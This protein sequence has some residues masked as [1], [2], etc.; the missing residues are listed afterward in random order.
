MSHY[1]KYSRLR[2]VR[3]WATWAN[4]RCPCP[5]EGVGMGWSWRPLPTQTIPRVE[6]S[7]TLISV[8]WCE[9][10]VT[11]CPSLFELKASLAPQALEIWMLEPAW[12]T[13]RE[14]RIWVW[15]PR[16]LKSFHGLSLL[17]NNQW[18]RAFLKNLLSELPSGCGPCALRSSGIKITP[19]V[20]LERIS[21]SNNCK[22]KESENMEIYTG[23]INFMQPLVILVCV[24][25][26]SNF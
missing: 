3:L 7:G 10:W 23:S 24:V 25:L 9:C 2:W 19:D 12:G 20:E 11:S 15:W 6:M 5:W 13:F 14:S 21:C 1:W 18:F 26:I 16:A 4:E 22:C 17:W 8:L